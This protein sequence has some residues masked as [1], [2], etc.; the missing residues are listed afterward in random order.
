MAEKERKQE[1]YEERKTKEEN[2]GKESS[3]EKCCIKGNQREDDPIAG[4]RHS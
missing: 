1:G 3:T 4:P 2:K